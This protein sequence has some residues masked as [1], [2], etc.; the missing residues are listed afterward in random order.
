MI[1]LIFKNLIYPLFIISL[2]IILLFFYYKYTRFS[3]IQK[4][5][6]YLDSDVLYNEYLKDLEE[7]SNQYKKIYDKVVLN[8]SNSAAM[9]IRDTSKYKTKNKKINLNFDDII[10]I[11]TQNNT[12]IVGSMIT[13]GRLSNYLHRHGYS[14]PIVPEFRCLT[15]GGLICGA[16]L[17]S[18]SFKYG[19]FPFI[20]QE[21][22]VILG[23]GEIRNVDENDAELFSAIPL[24]YGTL[25]TIISVKLKIVRIQKYVNIE[26]IPV[27]EYFKIQETLK[28]ILE[29]KN[30]RNYDFIEAIS[31]SKN[32]CLIIL[33]FISDNVN[34]LLEDY[35]FQPFFYQ[36]VL[37]KMEQGKRYFSMKIMDYYFRHDRGA[38][39]MYK[40][41]L[42][43]S[44]IFRL[45]NP[46]INSASD[47]KY[48]P[49]NIM[50]YL[51]KYRDIEI[52]DS[53]VPI[54]NVNN[55]LDFMDKNYDIYPIWFCPCLNLDATLQ[56]K[57]I[58]Y[59]KI[60]YYIRQI[61]EGNKEIMDILIDFLDKDGFYRLVIFC[62]IILNYSKEMES[63]I[64]ILGISDKIKYYTKDKQNIL[65]LIEKNKIFIY[66]NKF[67]F[68]F[69]ETEL[70]ISKEN[71]DIKDNEDFI[72]ILLESLKIKTS[73]F[74]L[75]LS[76]VN[77]DYF[78]DIGVYGKSKIILENKLNKLEKFTL[79]NKG[80]M[81][82]YAI[83]TFSRDEFEKNV[84][85]KKWYY[86]LHQKYGQG[87][88]PNIYD[89]LGTK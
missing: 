11:D 41:C 15:V 49:Q 14:L 10:K 88:Y 29:E 31:Y 19:L 87:K 74:G 55:I 83:T 21:Y 48:I 7:F 64:S 77:D 44:F 68:L 33:G 84:L 32:L 67:N 46:F 24:S 52:Q 13:M 60:K 43:D 18:S 51:L 53:V 45:F 27:Y 73:Y 72:N 36:S 23:N 78:V 6:N 80:F 57:K 9:T 25:C 66:S 89:K 37:K 4:S 3:C 34:E 1:K 17:E 16:G 26:I 81:G 28:K 54:D 20:C 50:K 2:V 56:Q 5:I 79:E 39:W 47:K 85:K 42:D 30:E 38:F 70:Y 82:Q 58:A 63:L 35:W 8:R 62:Y 12:A 76:S 71:K 65:K 22:N 61:L 59:K 86:Y 75:L 40:Y 69:S